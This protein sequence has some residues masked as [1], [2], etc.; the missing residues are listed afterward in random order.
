MY[1]PAQSVTSACADLFKDIVSV[2]TVLYSLK[3]MIESL[4]YLP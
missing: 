2:F 3:R 4:E 1:G